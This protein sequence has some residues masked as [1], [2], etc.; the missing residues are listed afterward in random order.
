MYSL[1][2]FIFNNVLFD[3]F[4]ALFFFSILFHNTI[5]YLQAKFLFFLIL[6]LYLSES[7]VYLLDYRTFLMGESTFQWLTYRCLSTLKQDRMGITHF[8]FKISRIQKN[9]P[10][11]HS[12]R[13][14]SAGYDP[15]IC[16]N[17]VNDCGWPLVVIS[18]AQIGYRCELECHIDRVQREQQLT[19]F[20]VC[21]CCPLRCFE[22]ANRQCFLTNRLYKSLITVIDFIAGLK[23]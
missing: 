13:S 19:L 2:C 5:Y 14:Q 23:D 22:W 10:V 7:L 20:I 15:V 16:S 17:S 1:F 21:H 11:I 6:W 3:L 9:W 12:A 4:I 18:H 8:R